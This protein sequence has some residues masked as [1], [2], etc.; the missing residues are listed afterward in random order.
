MTTKFMQIMD[1]QTGIA[2]AQIDYIREEVIAK[3]KMQAACEVF[4]KTLDDIKEE[5]EN[6]A[7][8]ILVERQNVLGYVFDVEYTELD[9]EGIFVYYDDGGYDG[10]LMKEL[11]KWEEME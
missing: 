5:W 6:K 1:A 4:N 9:C 2:S 10:V 7:I 8:A 11:I 3:K